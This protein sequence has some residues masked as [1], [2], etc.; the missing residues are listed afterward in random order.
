MLV[1]NPSQCGDEREQRGRVWLSA[2]LCRLIARL[3]GERRCCEHRTQEYSLS[4][5]T[6][7]PDPDEMNEQCA[8]WA[9]AAL[10]EFA[11]QVNGPQALSDTRN[12]DNVAASFLCDLALADERGWK[13]VDLLRVAHADAGQCLMARCSG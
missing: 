9:K 11:I 10:R 6:K 4:H 5:R 7:I 3:T 12:L 2:E 8:S 1:V 13:L